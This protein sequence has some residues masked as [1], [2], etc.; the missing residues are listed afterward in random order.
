[1]ATRTIHYCASYIQ[2]TDAVVDEHV[3]VGA[4]GGT[5]TGQCLGV[6]QCLQMEGKKHINSAAG[7]GR[8]SGSGGEV[9]S[10]GRVD[11]GVGRGLPV[12]S[13]RQPPAAEVNGVAVSSGVVGKRMNRTQS[14][15]L[16]NTRTGWESLPPRNRVAKKSD[17][18]RVAGLSED[19]KRCM[20][21]NVAQRE[22][23]GSCSSQ[24]TK[25]EEQKG[26]CGLL[27]CFGCCG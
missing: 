25:E 6:H 27:G 4:I 22:E 23:E 10:A 8:G 2:E 15:D 7:G 19:A 17:V 14:A 24:F 9:V 5:G 21:W 12:E 1:M 18:D 26:L 11:A 3:L 13:R 16:G 20:G